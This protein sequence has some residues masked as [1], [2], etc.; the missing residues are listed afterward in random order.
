MDYKFE[1]RNLNSNS[2]LKIS[3]ASGG[4]FSAIIKKSNVL[5]Y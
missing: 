3:M 2:K 4:G 5:N 1:K